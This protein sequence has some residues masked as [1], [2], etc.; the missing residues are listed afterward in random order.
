VEGDQLVGAVDVMDAD[1]VAKE[2]AGT[3]EAIRL[4]PVERNRIGPGARKSYWNPSARVESGQSCLFRRLHGH[5]GELN[6]KY[7]T[8]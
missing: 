8:P 7:R 3:G 4:R 6:V 2:A 5:V 1:Q